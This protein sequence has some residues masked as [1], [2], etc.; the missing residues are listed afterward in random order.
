MLAGVGGQGVLSLAAIL[1]EAARREGMVVKQGE[2][3]GMAQ[4]GGAVQAN[5]RLATEPIESDLIPRG[6][7]DLILGLEPIEALR[8]LDYLAPGGRLMTSAAPVDNIPDYPPLEEVLAAVGGIPGSLVI[9]A[10]AM[11]REAGTP[12]AANMVMAGAASVVLPISA[13]TIEDCVREGLAPKGGRAV[14]AGLRAFRAG[15]AAA[16]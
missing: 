15:R 7:A 9:D 11:A 4:R 1:A 16:A 13:A 3:H 14:E 6:G 2:V 5:L 8:Y 10:D 12:R